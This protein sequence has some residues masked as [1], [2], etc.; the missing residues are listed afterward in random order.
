MR[1]LTPIVFILAIVA[2]MPRAAKASD[3]EGCAD[4]K[5]FPRLE[6]CII[7]ECSAKQ[8]DSVEAADG[9]G[10]PQDANT[11]SVSYACPV[12]A[13]EQIKHDIDAQLRKAG[14]QSVA[15]DK[16]DATNPSVTARKNSQWIYWNASIEDS[17][18]TYSLTTA[19]AGEK[20]KAE[21][22]AQPPVLSTLKQC[23]VLECNSK[24]EDSVALRTAQK[25]ETSLAGNVQTV[26]LACHSI[27]PA[28][29]F[30]S[31]E[32]ELR[33]S[34]FEILF[35]DREQTGSEWLTGRA[36]KRWVELA[37]APDGESVTYALT[38]VPSAEVL[39]VAK[40]EQEEP[41]TAAPAPALEP[42][43]TPSPKPVQAGAV[44]AVSI[45]APVLKA[46]PA[47]P[48][49][50][51][52][53]AAPVVTFIPPKPIL[54]APLEAAPDV[55]SSIRGD[56]V[57]DMLVDVSEDGTVTKAELTGKITKNVLKLK[58]AA[59]EAVSH[60]RFEPA[61]QDGRIVAAV[62][63]DVRMHFHG[64]PWLF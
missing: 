45:P 5:L 6:G 3:A 64:R 14:Y 49:A 63:I 46:P 9:S 12:T 16:G 40:P 18:I 39:T 29:A 48:V 58:S 51:N 1:A 23:E 56:V 30:S 25:G 47:A 50:T 54:E 24:S 27:S 17:A 44:Q 53:V 32:R 11:N 28:Q 41:T 34:G 60:W 31:V 4:L 8:H 52:A 2:T 22:C 55:I 37:S 20:F 62:K 33:M 57:I 15:E 42:A 21:T 13:H 7:V 19:S 35:S 38:V 59:L 26:T 61:R 43:P 36:G 10:F